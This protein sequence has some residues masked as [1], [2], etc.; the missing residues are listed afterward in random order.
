MRQLGSGRRWELIWLAILL[1]GGGPYS[2][3][4]K[5]GREL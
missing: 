4:G 3:D 5:L 2:L 1:R